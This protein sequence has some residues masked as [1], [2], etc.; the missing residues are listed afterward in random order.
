MASLHTVTIQA[1]ASEIVY[2]WPFGM[3]ALLYMALTPE[4]LVNFGY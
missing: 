4:W 3:L 2:A 1:K